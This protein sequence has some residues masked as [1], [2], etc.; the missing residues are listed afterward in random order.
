MMNPATSRV[1]G[2]T[3]AN[4]DLTGQGRTNRRAMAEDAVK[5]LEAST[6][7]TAMFGAASANLKSTE[8]LWAMINKGAKALVDMASK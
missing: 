8:S 1:S 6:A 4:L 5:D 3:Q 7:E 2:D